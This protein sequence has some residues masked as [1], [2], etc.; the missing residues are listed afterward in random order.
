MLIESI[1]EQLKNCLYG[2]TTSK[3][4]HI[5]TINE[6][7]YDCLP[8]CIKTGLISRQDLTGGYW[9]K[10]GIPL[11]KLSD[12]LDVVAEDEKESQTIQRFKEDY[13]QRREVCPLALEIIGD[14]LW[15]ADGRHRLTAYREAAEEDRTLS[16]IECW[17]RIR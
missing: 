14:D 7:P 13:L 3:N 6:V 17:V 16:E 12:I 9:V 1:N 11:G 8:K 4:V 2:N 15:V 10:M 5:M